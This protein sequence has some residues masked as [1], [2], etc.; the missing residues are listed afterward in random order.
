MGLSLEI[1]QAIPRG[2]FSHPQGSGQRPGLDEVGHVIHENEASTNGSSVIYDTS[3]EDV[4]T[5][6]DSIHWSIQQDIQDRF[7]L[8]GDSNQTIMDPLL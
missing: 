5:V 1:L 8:H 2:Q 3:V 7:V 4:I 6:S